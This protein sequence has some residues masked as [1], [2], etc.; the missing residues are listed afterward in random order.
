MI[1]KLKIKKAKLEDVDFIV[2]SLIEAEKNNTKVL[3]YS[4]I[5]NLKISKV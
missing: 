3:S 1:E 5:F 2:E 4:T